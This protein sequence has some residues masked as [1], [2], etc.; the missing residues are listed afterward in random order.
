M[1]SNYGGHIVPY[2]EKANSK[3]ILMFGAASDQG[4]NATSKVYPAEC[5]QVFCIGAANSAGKADSAAESQANY[6]FPGGEL[7]DIK[8]QG[9]DRTPEHAF[10]S[11]FA[12]ALASGLTALILDCTQIVGYGKKYRSSIKTKDRMDAIFEGMIRDK[13]SKYIP[14]PKFFTPELA[15]SDWNVDGKKMLEKLVETIIRYES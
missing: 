11:S 5:D 8:A 13:T 9:C 2:I 10:G 1:T 6:V 7:S 3:G 15:K 14:V 12:M 4:K